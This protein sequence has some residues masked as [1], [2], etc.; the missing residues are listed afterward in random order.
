MKVSFVIPNFNGEKILS[1]NLPRVLDAAKLYAKDS[2]RITEVILVDDCSTDSSV[3]VIKDIF[4]KIQHKFIVTKIL[5]SSVNR[6]F[7]STVNTGAKVATGEILILLNTDVYPEKQGDFFSLSLKHFKDPELF[8]VGF[9]DKSVEGDRVILRGRGVGVW[10]RG[11]LLHRRGEI[12]N[13]TTLWVSGGS[14]AFRKSIWDELG[15]MNELYNPFYWEDIDLSYRAQ[16][17]GYKILFDPRTVV[18]H[19]HEEGSIK[20]SRKPFA[21]RTI[22]YRNQLQFVWLNV[23]DLSLI[24]AHLAWLPFHLFN[25]LVKG[26]VGLLL[27][28]FHAL[29]RFPMIMKKRR[30]SAKRIRFSDSE[31]VK[32]FRSEMI[33]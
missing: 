23:T 6:G 22:S 33:E 21:I 31:I 8:A 19:E 26:D 11:F 20:K 32:Y 2:T 28:L 7:S 25:T 5:T 17:I 4:S 24:A 27:G 12:D 15:G 30:E 13:H 16:K 29:G 10:K 18:M 1:K 3:D 9:M 14:S